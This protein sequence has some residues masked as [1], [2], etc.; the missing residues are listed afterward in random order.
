MDA[1]PGDIILFHNGCNP[2]VPRAEVFKIIRAAQKN[3]TAV[4]A[5]SARDTIKKAGRNKFVEKTISREGI[6]L[7][8]APQAIEFNLAKRVFKKAFIDSFK[9]TED[10][11]LVERLGEKVK[12]I[13]TNFKNI[14]ITYPE[15]INFIKQSFKL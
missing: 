9:S 4:L 14:K 15:D 8:Q 3:K 12:I 2:L 11:T 1:K 5:W 7:A 10:V 6:Y 13:P